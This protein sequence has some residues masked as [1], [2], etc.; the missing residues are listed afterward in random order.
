M[1]LDLSEILNVCEEL[2]SDMQRFFNT[3]TRVLQEGTENLLTF[4]QLYKIRVNV[5]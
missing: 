2:D 4:V 5:T 3:S 1:P